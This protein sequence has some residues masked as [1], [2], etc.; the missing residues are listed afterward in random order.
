MATKAI[1]E[2]ED[3]TGVA[4]DPS[5]YSDS[6]DEKTLVDVEDGRINLEIDS[7]VGRAL[8]KF[9]PAHID[10]GLIPFESEP[11]TNVSVQWDT[12]LNIVIQV[13]G[14]RGDVQPFLALGNELQRHGH[15][16]RLATHSVFKQFVQQAGLE[17][18]GIG[19]DPAQLMAYMVKNPGLIPGMKTLREGE[20]QRK[21]AMIAEMLDGCW[22]SCIEPDP[23][24]RVPFVAQAII[25]NPVSFAHVHYVCGFFFR[26]MPTY[27]PP[28]DL[29]AFLT[30]GPAPVYIGFGSI[31]IDDAP[32][33]TA[34]LLEAIKD[35]GVRAII[36]RGWSKLGEDTATE[37]IYYLGDCPHEWLFERVSAVVHHGGAGTTACGLVNA[38]PTLVVPFFGDQPF[39]GQMIASARA[40][41]EPIPYK[42]LNSRNLAGAIEYCLSKA[43]IAAADDISRKMRH[44]NGVQQA[45][46]SFHRQ[47]PRDRMNCQVVPRE[48]A[49][50]L[51][52]H[53]KVPM[54][55]SY[56]AVEVLC[57][58]PELKFKRKH[59]RHYGSSPILIRNRRWDPVTSAG[60]AGLHLAT[61]VTTSTLGMFA[62]PVKVYFDG[63]KSESEPK[64]QARL[65]G[66][67]GLAFAKGVNHLAVGTF[68]G[69][70]VDVP[71][72]L[73][74]GFRNVPR[75]WGED[76]KDQEEITGWKS[77]ATVA[78]KSLVHGFYD[79]VGG[80][81][82]KPYKGARNE[83]IIG[84][85][86]G[87]AKGL[88][89]I[90]YEP[91]YGRTA[92]DIL[93]KF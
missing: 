30:S 2:L 52:T 32:R 36:S 86:K 22:K 31:V 82:Y 85:A 26:E 11:I 10:D 13:V 92:L 21:R 87:C 23:D 14:S 34:I 73:A 46:A 88:T 1:A 20:I 27:T 83:G 76:V 91:I 28:P 8:S 38:R 43:A 80:S 66:K 45:V 47:L 59:L 42:V 15:R 64:S 39:W 5:K 44:E 50:W 67:A 78:G 51:Y 70:M 58:A 65:H 68:K 63:T 29:A 72:A 79:G 62:D 41:P 48:P 16:V 84:F 75:L 54:R 40:G 90:V 24:S 93:R 35:T 55:L 57:R 25:A 89:G 17:F 53:C 6:D 33:L 12:P 19:G 69:G 77:G 74:E 37:N 18:Y 9:A 61:D 81:F 49:T 56:R 3:D 71:L 60:S 7:K 4:S